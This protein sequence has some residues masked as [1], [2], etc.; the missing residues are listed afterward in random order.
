M[1]EKLKV[2]HGLPKL[3]VHEK[4]VLYA[5]FNGKITPEISGTV[6]VSPSNT[7]TFTPS[8]CGYGLRSQAYN[9][10]IPLKIAFKSPMKDNVYT[11]DFWVD[12]SFIKESDMTD[13]SNGKEQYGAYLNT[14]VT[15]TG[16]IR[17]FAFHKHNNGTYSNLIRFYTTEG[18]RDLYAPIRLGINHYRIIRDGNTF[19]IYVNGSLFHKDTYN[20]ISDGSISNLTYLSVRD[21]TACVSEVR[22][23]NADLGDSFTTLPQDFIDGK[24]IVVPA[25]NQRQSYGDPVLH[26]VTE[27][28]VKN[29]PMDVLGTIY[30]SNDKDGDNLER[31]FTNP[32]LRTCYAYD[33]E[34]GNS[35]I[36]I[37]GFDN[38][39]ITG[40]FDTDT[41]VARVV[42]SSYAPN[43]KL[44]L[45]SVVGLSVGDT[46]RVVE[47]AETSIYYSKVEVTIQSI[48]VNEKSIG[49]TSTDWNVV[50]G[51]HYIFET[52]A[53]SSS[54]VV[55]TVEGATVNG[56]W[57]GLGTNVATFTLGSNTNIAGKD[58]VVTYCLN[59][60][61]NSSPYP[62][63]PSEV[64]RGYDEFGNELEPVTSINLKDN[65]KNKISGSILEC[66][67]SLKHQC[68]SSLLPYNDPSWIEFSDDGYNFNTLSSIASTQQGYYAQCLVEIDLVKFIENKMGI[69]IPGN[70]LQWLNANIKNIRCRALAKGNNNNNNNCYIK[71]LNT[72]NS[73]SINS[74]NATN[75]NNTIQPIQGIFSPEGLL[76]DMKYYFLIHS[77]SLT[78]AGTDVI[79]SMVVIQDI[80]LDLELKTNS[81]YD[82]LYTKNLASREGYCNPILVDKQTK[83][84]KRLLPSTAPFSTEVLV[85]NPTT[86]STPITTLIKGT[87]N[88]MT[89][90]GSG[91]SC[92]EHDVMRGLIGKLGMESH[93][94][95]ND[96][97]NKLTYY[98]V[99][100][101]DQRTKIVPRQYYLHNYAK[102]EISDGDVPKDMSLLAVAYDLVV[103]DSKEVAMKTLCHVIEN[104]KRTE[105]ITH[106]YVLPNRP[107]I[108]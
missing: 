67:H 74:S 94:Y 70:K 40:V 31:C 8:V 44:Y 50:A 10:S 18:N 24:A 79:K 57:S 100:D 23:V 62:K 108:K 54:P 71:Y 48:D 69:E 47:V 56:T 97:L 89:T 78:V 77:D 32:E 17:F 34:Q 73:W 26:Q 7:F 38:T 80:Q 96:T 68:A 14:N 64:I 66:P 88:V 82:Y 103:T 85:H 33:W 76:K 5:S 92:N 90:L 87:D 36:R 16:D 84:V 49:I 3:P 2:Y 60:K 59:A 41:A 4:T 106:T 101:H 107:L 30:D 55:K 6:N 9:Q 35:K 105:Y 99:S 98:P 83:E 15:S 53:S 91:S 42:K 58:L 51:R 29:Q 43:N 63:M 1:K 104:G 28:V 102:N 37:T 95:T 25:L 52:T 20:I 81:L 45:D 93:L 72:V 13:V 75:P 46:V 22:L 65:F 12:T 39:I 11:L 19:S 21:L 86:M 27:L 61:G